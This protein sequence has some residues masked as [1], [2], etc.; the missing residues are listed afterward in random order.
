MSNAFKPEP[1]SHQEEEAMLAVW[2]TGTGFIKDFLEKVPEPQPHYNTFTSTIKNLE[3]KG[4]LSGR[5]RGLMYEYTPLISEEEY[6]KH[7]LRDVVQNYFSNSYKDLVA[8]FAREQKISERELKEVMDMI[9]KN[10][11]C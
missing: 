3:K 7:F 8:F 2:K 11:S 9:Q 1:L 6:K 4:Y 5:K 10:R